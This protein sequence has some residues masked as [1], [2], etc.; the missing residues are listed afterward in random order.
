MEIMT[1]QQ[2]APSDNKNYIIGIGASAGGLEALH[3]LF[4]NMPP[5]TSFSFVVIQ[6]L[7]PDHKSL[8]SE[9]LAKHTMMRVYEA[10]EGT[11]LQSNCIY[12]IPSKKL[13][14]IKNGALH[15]DEKLKTRQPNDAIDFF[16]ES[17]ALDKKDKAGAIILSG[18]GTDGTKGIEVIKKNG[19]FV[20]VQDPMSAAFDGMPN[21]A[22]ATGLAD[23]VLPPDMIADEMIEFIQEAPLVKSFSL[24]TQKEEAILREILQMLQSS[25]G[26]DFNNYKRPTLFRRMAKRMAETG[27]STLEEYRHYLKKN[28]G[29]VKI[30]GNEFLI[31]VTKFFRDTDAFDLIRTKVI[32]GIVNGKSDEE[33]I[34]VWSMACSTGE[35]AYSLAILFAEYM[36]KNRPAMQVKIFATD[37]DA[38]ALDTASKGIYPAAIIKDV[39]P[40]LLEKYFIKEEH[41][42]RISPSIRKMVVFASHNILKDP[43]FSKVDLISCRNMLIYLDTYL[44][45]KILNKFYFA[46]NLNAYL[47]MGTSE[48]IGM[49]SPAMEEIS[50]KWKIYRC[51]SKDNTI[52]RETFLSPLENRVYTLPTAKSKNP[53][54]NMSE[55]FKETITEERLIAGILLD[56]EFNVKQATGNFKEFL[57]FPQDNFNFNVLKLVAPDLAIA[58][59]VSLRK[60]VAQNEKIT[61]KRI[62]VGG[63]SQVKKYVNVIIKPYVQNKD[64][65]QPFIYMILEEE[66]MEE[67]IFKTITDTTVTSSGRIDELEK[68][69]NHTRE[70]LQAVIEELESANE[71]MQSSNEEMISTNEEL[72][73]TN[74]ELQSL[75][76]E[77][78]TVSAEH[79]NKIKE[80]LELNDDLDNYFSNAHVGQI[81]IDPK[82]MVRKFSPGIKPVINLITTDIGRSIADITTNIKNYNLINDVKEVM[83][84]GKPIEKEVMLQNNGSH[85]L[86]RIN[87]YIKKDKSTDGTVINFMDVTES[88]KLSGMIEAVFNTSP[89]G[90][91]AK[92]TLRNAEN[93]IV[94]FEYLVV[95]SKYE[96]LYDV[97]SDN[98]IGSRMSEILPWVT[99]DYLRLCISVV[100]TGE[101][102]RT[103]TY[104]SKKDIW[105]ETTIAKMFD[106][107]VSTHMDITDKK[108]SEQM[109]ATSYEELQNASRLLSDSNVQL[110]RSNMDLMQ[111]ASVASHDLKEPLRKIQA[112]GNM[113]ESKLSHKL[114]ENELGYLQKMVSA[115][116][117]MQILIEDVLTLSKLS[118]NQLPRT[119][120]HLTQVIKH[121]TDDLEILIKEKNAEIR[122]GEL[123]QIEAVPGQVH[124]LFQNLV[125]NALKFND[126]EL[127]IIHIRSIPVTPKIM[128]EAEADPTRRYVAIEVSDNGIGFEQ[129]YKDTIFGLFQRLNGRLYD[130]TGIGLAIVKKILENHDGYINANSTVNKGTVFTILFPQ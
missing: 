116:G 16:L 70:N 86:M 98:V 74:E 1:K 4:D 97:K 120:V 23:L 68:E 64:Y 33:V 35:E 12:V 125:S 71:E 90:I 24:T 37:I 52:E 103:E 117:R 30:L 19:G 95:N 112:F 114:E 67:K 107:I 73:S 60:S 58:L 57:Q 6:H 61:I 94:D 102:A 20:V 83:R 124:Q 72:Q 50:R 56:R 51:V 27:L 91:S 108:K 22:L 15:L 89:N 17:L 45:S 62:A 32:P 122:F 38:T 79:Q 126:K 47:F 84:S 110:E 63:P 49:L 96:E 78:H 87:P 18:T 115:S 118:N 34:K 42:Y 54:N 66:K 93:E 25:T 5:D 119:K 59:G 31:N 85:Y 76:E 121:I 3:E 7:S 65:L 55:L 88:K 101:I 104:L 2:P 75:N 21:S 80:L 127:P 43:P 111:F 46:L 128:R 48:H 36:A 44:Q 106:G 82:L 11:I 41:S 129:E 81:F 113:L 13:L 29:E 100:E 9:L 40:A 10:E 39:P 109:L 28:E 130:G 26:H 105:M 53:L 8:L 69:L 99:K 14:T 77:L 92:R 123:P